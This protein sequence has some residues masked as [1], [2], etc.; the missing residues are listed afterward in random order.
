V[1]LARCVSAQFLVIRCWL[2]SSLPDVGHHM[3][4]CT[5]Y[6]SFRPPA[7]S[8]VLA[9]RFFL[10]AQ[11]LSMTSW[12]ACA[13]QRDESV[14]DRDTNFSQIAQQQ[15]HRC[16]QQEQ[17]VPV[18]MCQ[19]WISLSSWVISKTLC[20]VND[21]TFPNSILRRSG[22]DIGKLRASSSFTTRP[23]TRIPTCVKQTFA[24]VYLFGGATNHRTHEVSGTGTL[25]TGCGAAR[26]TLD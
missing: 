17:R 12:S 22:Y 15:S 26:P 4:A 5:E 19:S 24:L 20:A 16:V 13:P 23:E 14:S 11:P 9:N 7:S 21:L 18:Y 8:G 6:R 2:S 1:D 25:A 10:V 3:H